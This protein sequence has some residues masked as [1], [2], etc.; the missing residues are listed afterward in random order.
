MTSCDSGPR[1]R[2]SQSVLPDYSGGRGGFVYRTD[3]R[4]FASGTAV[5]S[6]QTSMLSEK[7]KPATRG[8]A[9]PLPADGVDLPLVL[10]KRQLASILCCT[11]RHIEHLTK[12]GVLPAVR[13]GRTVR[14]RREAVL[15][16]LVKLED[17][18]P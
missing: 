11:T 16:A 8:E 17:P 7:L 6:G 15:R 12:R 3:F 18:C 10:T 5:L 2:S 9:I 13:L 4:G 14:Y 1:N